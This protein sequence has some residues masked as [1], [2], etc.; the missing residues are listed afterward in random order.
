MLLSRLDL[1]PTTLRILGSGK[2]IQIL[3]QPPLLYKYKIKKGRIKNPNHSQGI[4]CS[5][6][7]QSA[8]GAKK[9]I[10]RKL[11]P[12]FTKILGTFGTKGAVIVGIGSSEVEIRK[13]DPVILKELRNFRLKKI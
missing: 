5:C 7:A 8:E 10:G 4:V 2:L 13:S 9:I 6:L 11:E 1:P 12:P 3:N